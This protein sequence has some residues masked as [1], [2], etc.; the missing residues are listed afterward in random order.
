MPSPK[1]TFHVTG[2]PHQMPKTPRT[3]L[4]PLSV[5]R[6]A[7]TAQ[8]AGEQ[9]SLPKKGADGGWSQHRPSTRPARPE[10]DSLRSRPQ[11]GPS[12][13]S[14]TEGQGAPRP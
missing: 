12:G 5:G 3:L 10:T 2:Q 6:A 14:Q 8:G 1:L 4:M 7:L 9:L 11:P 13:L